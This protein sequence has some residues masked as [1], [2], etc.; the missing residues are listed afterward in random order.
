[1]A[2]PADTS[3]PRRGARKARRAEKAPSGGWRTIAAKEMADHLASMRFFVLL[4][5]VAV[6]A[7]VPLLF[8]SN[9][10]SSQAPTLSGTPALFLALF[11]VG[12]KS[13]GSMTTVAFVGLLVPA[14][15]HRLRVRRDQHRAQPGHA[16]RGC[17]PSRSTATTWS[18]ASS[19]PGSRSSR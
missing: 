2:A 9:D 5:V 7:V 19:W 11:V 1:M 12:S 18:T 10:I 15:R 8:V 13:I 17:S 3:K 16:W 4:L 6:A 14:R